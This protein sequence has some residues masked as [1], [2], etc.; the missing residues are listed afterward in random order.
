MRRRGEAPDTGTETGTSDRFPLKPAVAQ[1]GNRAVSATAPYFIHVEL[2]EMLRIQDS[3]LVQA[4]AHHHAF[5]AAVRGANVV[6]VEHGTN[7]ADDEREVYRDR[8]VGI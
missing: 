6:P 3:L 1:I 8:Y 4:A 5:H 7:N 2:Q